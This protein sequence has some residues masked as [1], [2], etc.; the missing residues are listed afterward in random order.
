MEAIEIAGNTA[1]L[2]PATFDSQLGIFGFIRKLNLSYISRTSG[3][4]PL[5]QAETLLTWRLSELRLSGTTLNTA[6]IDAL[7]TYLAH[8]QST[9]LHELYLDNSYLAGRDIATLLHS[10]MQ[11]DGD[12]RNLHFDISQ[13]HITKDLEYVTQA[14]SSGMAPS[15]LSM[16]AIEYREESTFRKVL[17]ALTV[18]KTI[19]YLDLSQTAL[20]GAASEDTCRAFKKLFAENDTIVEL[21][22]SGEESRLATSRFG[23]G[24]NDALT[25]L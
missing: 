15:H 13:S 18:N 16:R 3:S 21:N 6:T 8:P 22:L 4:E 9:S 7:A 10:M 23:S 11:G 1:R 19:Q 25:G 17:S 24:I 14:I 2:N 20:P 5:L 12:H